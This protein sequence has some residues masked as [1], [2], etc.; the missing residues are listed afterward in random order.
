[1]SRRVLLGTALA[2]VAQLAV[3]CGDSHRK[4]KAVG[5][6]SPTVSAVDGTVVMVIRHGEKPTSGRTGIDDSGR[7][8]R[9]SLTARGWERARALPGLFT[10]PRAGL[11]RPATVFAAADHGPHAGA[12]RMRQT[13]TPL[14]RHLRLTV[15]TDF[16]EG[17]E[18]QLAQAALTAPRPVLICWEHTR[19]PAIVAGL[20]AVDA[21]GVPSVWP[22]RFDLVWVFRHRAGTWSFTQVEQHLLPGDQ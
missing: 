4:A 11:A 5:S 19:I 7:P 12:H 16:A 8:D 21:P 15:D 17:S 3:G 2:S 9:K 6:S 13:V 22:D 1:M 10:A 14:A 18:Q 20:G